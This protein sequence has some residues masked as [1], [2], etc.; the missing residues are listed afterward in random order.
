M[1]PHYPTR[2]PH[3]LRPQFSQGLGS[4]S[5]TEAWS[6]N[7]LL[8]MCWWPPLELETNLGLSLFQCP[9]HARMERGIFLELTV[10]AASPNSWKTGPI[11]IYFSVTPSMGVL[12]PFLRKGKVSTLWCLS[13]EQ[14][15]QPTRP[16]APE[17]LGT[18]SPTREQPMA[19]ASYVAEDGIG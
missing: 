15:F 1:S 3:S 10:Q 7:P 16:L 4:S 9:L 12:F 14:Q 2:P 11:R 8:Y 6:H 18:K 5:L 19:S 17:L 13:W